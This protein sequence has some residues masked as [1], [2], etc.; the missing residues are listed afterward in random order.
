MA[1]PT[2]T[3]GKKKGRKWLLYA[4]GAGALLA[5]LVLIAKR[6][7]SS[8]SE[9]TTSTIASPA[10]GAAGAST[11]EGSQITSAIAA[12]N[13]DLKTQ[14]SESR[15]Q[16]HELVSGFSS[17]ITSLQNSQNQLQSKIEALPS[18]S[19]STASTASSGAGGSS[20][21]GGGSSGGGG[22]SAASA[23]SSKQAAAPQVNTQAGNPRKGLDYTETKYKGK[24]AHQYSHA[25]PGGE[26]PGKNLVIV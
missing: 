7:G 13:E 4:A 5:L 19:A 1:E 2:Q 18:A 6:K 15:E 26:G 24:N 16:E 25:V 14:Q 17:A 21:G 20:G 10:E 22:G 11:G 12:F 8:S 23:A 3:A 9:G